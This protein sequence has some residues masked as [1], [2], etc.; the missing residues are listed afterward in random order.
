M[1]KVL[2]ALI[3]VESRPEKVGPRITALREALGLSKAQFADSIELNR[4]TQTKVEA[5]KEGLDISKAIAIATLYGVGLDFTYRGDLS[6]L[7]LELRQK[8][9]VNLASFSTRS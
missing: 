9:I 6:D 7:P 4:S 3:P 1:A 2:L 5:G 8:V